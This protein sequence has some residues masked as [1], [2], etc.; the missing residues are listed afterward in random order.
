MATKIQLRN[1]TSSSWSSANPI[2]AQGEPGL[3]TNTSKIKY[4]NGTSAWNCLPYANGENCGSACGVEALARIN[5]TNVAIGYGSGATFQGAAAV[6]VGNFAGNRDQGAFAVAIGCGAGT[7]TQG[8][9]A[10]AIGCFAGNC[11]QHVAA[12][13]VGT[14]AGS[15]NQGTGAVAIGP[16]AASYRQ[17]C[18]AIAIGSDAGAYSQSEYGVAV[19]FVAGESYQGYQS[20]AIGSNAGRGHHTCTSYT[21]LVCGTTLSVN[22]TSCIIAGMRVHGTGICGCQRV[23][24][25]CNGTTVT[26]VN[27]NTQTPSGVLIFESGQCVNA[28]AVGFSAG[29]NN[30]RQGAVAVGT[31][32]GFYCQ[33]AGAV[34]IGPQTAY[35]NQGSAAISI[36]ALAGSCTQQSAAIAIGTFAGQ[37]CQQTNAIAIGSTAGFTNQSPGSI[38]IGTAAGH[39]TQG[40]GSIAIGCGAG[41][42]LQG[43]TS[44]AIGCYAGRCGQH[45]C[46]VAIGHT[47]GQNQQGNNTVAIG[48]TA[49]LNAQGNNA[50]AIGNGAGICSQ[51]TNSV[52]INADSASLNVYNSGLYVNPVRTDTSNVSVATYYNTDTKEITYAPVGGILNSFQQVTITS[53]G[54]CGGGNGSVTY[55]VSN[56]APITSTGILFSVCSAGNH[57][58]AGT[59]CAGSQTVS[60]TN[61][62]GGNTPYVAYAY[63]TTLAGTV[64]SH[65]AVGRTGLCLIEGTLIA[66]S[67]GTYKSIEDINSSDLLLAWNFDKGCYAEAYPLWIKRS[68]SALTYNLLSFSDGST[69][70]TV[71]QHRI[72]NKEAGAF[73]YPMTDD[74]PIGTT[75]VNQY[76]VEVQLV[77]KEVINQLVQY[78][79]VITDY[80]VNL[81][82]NGVLTSN[83]FN[84]IYPIV[85][86][87]FVKTERALRDRSEF[88]GV[89]EKFYTGL[90][91]AEQLYDADMIKWYVHRLEI[92]EKNSL[93]LVV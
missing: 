9:V 69:L 14:C 85:N 18:F 10:V 34:A 40:V 39:C 6:A 87:Q 61:I 44:V 2:L 88:N 77:K 78:Y 59:A 25:I 89:P 5:A 7:V 28:T 76:G 43:I 91:L 46:A 33:G 4:G 48:S 20:T 47:A 67:N 37:Y 42:F 32:A 84:N 65:P 23:A 35:N 64:Y 55:C 53:T 72:Y 92:L 54:G 38:A 58:G 16:S 12:V 82:A 24:S 29:I 19:G 50:I 63:V 27:V 26:L 22:T 11:N 52:V 45:A 62:G 36:G 86:M 70:G 31:C 93:H 60:W 74:T 51:P 75:T 41:S 21:G 81:F 13:A 8:A 83:R 57:Y 68:E 73:T 56:V 71:D 15:V 3:E 90:R 17:G 80:H 30:Q 66:L 79:N 49:G 1:D